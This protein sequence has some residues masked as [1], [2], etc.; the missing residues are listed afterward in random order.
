MSQG[1][2]HKNVLEKYLYIRLEYENLVSGLI[3]FFDIKDV[4]ILLLEGK[5]NLV[6]ILQ[7]EIKKI[8]I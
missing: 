6:K 7:D 3:S 4:A 8:D 2:I 5:D 1:V